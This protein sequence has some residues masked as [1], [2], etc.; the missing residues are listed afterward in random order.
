LEEKIMSKLPLA[1]IMALCLSSQAFA[2]T[3]PSHRHHRRAPPAP[4]A[5]KYSAIMPIASAAPGITRNA[6]ECA[7]DVAEAKWGAGGALLGYSCVTPSA[8]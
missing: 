8:N 6:N 2:E 5:E 3:A 7:P 4:L 1:V